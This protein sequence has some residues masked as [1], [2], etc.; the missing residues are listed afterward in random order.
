MFCTCKRCCPSIFDTMF[1]GPRQQNSTAF[2]KGGN[3]GHTNGKQTASQR[4][5]QSG[6]PS[7]SQDSAKVHNT[8]GRNTHARRSN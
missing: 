3:R 5:E 7:K 8:K 2:K 1:S 4:R 6:R